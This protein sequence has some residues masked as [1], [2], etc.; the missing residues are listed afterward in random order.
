MLNTIVPTTREIFFALRGNL[1]LYLSLSML[2]EEEDSEEE[3]TEDTEEDGEEEDKD[4]A[5]SSPRYPTQITLYQ[6]L[7]AYQE[8]KHEEEYQGERNLDL[9][10]Y[11]KPDWMVD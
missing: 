6:L 2:L 8:M 5:L 11:S 10:D 1:C 4:I 3:V 9:F 7:K